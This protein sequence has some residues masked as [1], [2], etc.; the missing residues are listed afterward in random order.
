MPRLHLFEFGDLPWLP[1]ALRDGLTGYLEALVTR[2]A[3]FK[4]IVP[5]LNDLLARTGQHRIVDLAAG[6]GGPLVGILG[7]LRAADGAPVEVQLTDR[8]P[9]LQAF[10]RAAERTGGAIS[11]SSEP[12]DALAVAPE[13]TGVRT[14]FN[15][16]HHF[17]PDSAR[18]ILR[19]AALQKQPIAIFESTERSALAAFTLM[20]FSP[21]QVL[22]VTPSVRPLRASQVV[23]TYLLP[24][25]PLIITWDAV[26]SCLRAYSPDELL[27]LAKEA[28]PEGYTWEAGQ[29]RI[30]KTLS[31]ITYLIGAPAHST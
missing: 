7:F 6:A 25:L 9:N 3:F 11:F 2:F 4:P 26:I 5:K 23:F 19:D 13:L 21:L 18:G 24:V 17:R 29:V 16:F 8:F 20:L 14:V 27:S 22:L 30:P 12:V 28:A 1:R 10:R 15:A 31:H